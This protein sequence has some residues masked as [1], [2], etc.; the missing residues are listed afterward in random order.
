MTKDFVIG[1]SSLKEGKHI[2]NYKVGG[3]FFEQFENSE[4]QKG[5]LEVEVELD[6]KPTLMNARFQIDGEVV[7]MCDRCTDDYSQK[8][9]LTSELIYK[10]SDEQMEDENIVVVFPNEF[11][12]DVSHPIYEFIITS[13]PGKRLHPNGT[14]NEEMLKIMDNYLL[15]SSNEEE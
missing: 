12:I 13:L 7:V 5:E 1:F 2:F 10:F 6:K 8:V 15:V 11:Q 14:C 4:I 9:N 3:S